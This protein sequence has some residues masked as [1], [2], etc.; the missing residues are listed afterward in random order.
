M[1]SNILSAGNKGPSIAATIA[2]FSTSAVLALAPT[3]A[4]A[5][6]IGGM[7]GTAMA[8]QTQ[9]NAYR[10]LS[11]GYGHTRSHVASRRDSDSDDH[12]SSG[13]ERDALDP[14]TIDRAS[15]P[16]NKLAKF[17]ASGGLAQASERDASAGQG[18]SSGRSFDDQPAFNPSR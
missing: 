14:G 9:V 16:A 17:T 10:G 12:A 11:G 2:A 13:G 18:A 4:S 3:K 6:D 7:I 15:Q 5:F 8:I 1:K